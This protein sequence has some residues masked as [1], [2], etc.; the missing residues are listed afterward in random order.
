MSRRSSRGRKIYRRPSWARETRPQGKSGVFWYG[1]I[2]LKL[3]TDEIW[4]SVLLFMSNK[5]IWISIN[6]ICSNTIRKH[7]HIDVYRL[8]LKF[9]ANIFCEFIKWTL[10]VKSKYARPLIQGKR[11]Y[12]KRFNQDHVDSKKGTLKGGFSVDHKCP[13]KVV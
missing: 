2:T 13:A 12:Y 10:W 8:I 3:N 11:S 5:Y 6:E 4:Y 1:A 7:W 9:Y